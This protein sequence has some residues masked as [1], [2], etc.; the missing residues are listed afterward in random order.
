[1]PAP[2][3]G[4]ANGGHHGIWFLRYHVTRPRFTL[5]SLHVALQVRPVY[6]YL[7][8]HGEQFEYKVQSRVDATGK[9]CSIPVLL[10]RMKLKDLDG[11]G[12]LMFLHDDREA[13]ND[14]PSPLFKTEGKLLKETTEGRGIQTNRT[15][16]LKPCTCCFP[17]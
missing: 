16:I 2:H 9:R 7:L 15:P 14:I 6:S 13:R 1:M 8:V 4:V 5:W 10:P 11:G 12:I 17:C 3:A